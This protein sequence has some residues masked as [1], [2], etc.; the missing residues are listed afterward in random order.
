MLASL[1]ETR[2][3]EFGLHRLENWKVYEMKFRKDD[4]KD[5]KILMINNWKRRD[6]IE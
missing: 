6:Q 2:H 1:R 4:F 5:N 3:R